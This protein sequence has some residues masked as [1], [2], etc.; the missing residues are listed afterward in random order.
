MKEVVDN[1]TLW[2]EAARVGMVFGLFSSA[3]LGLKEASALTGSTFVVTAA[4]IILWA[5]E[6]FGCILLM[7]KYMLD[8]IEK[9]K[10]MQQPGKYRP[11]KGPM[12]TCDL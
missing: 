7:K 9:H 1:K 2:N 4:A 8:E 3:C 6:F 5:V 10:G 12:Y 11:S